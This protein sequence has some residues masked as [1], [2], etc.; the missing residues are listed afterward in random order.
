MRY[1]PEPL[2]FVVLDDHELV[3]LGIAAQLGRDFPD[4]SLA[5]SGPSL[6]DAVQHSDGCD[7]AVVD[8][9]LGDG[10][11]VADVVSRFTSRGVPVVVVSAMAR[12]EALS[13]AFSAGA[14]SFVTKTSDVQNLTLGVRAALRGTTWIAPDLAGALLRE[15]SRVGLSPQERRALVLYASGLTLDAVARRMDIS[16]A[17]ARYYLE[18]VRAKYASVGVR[19]RTKLELHQVARDDGLVP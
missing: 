5:Y 12:P 9:D 8:L 2:R 10:S 19:A 11:T 4:S 14:S 16:P 7:C 1:V 18:R 17:T 3:R 6:A 15:S 13:A